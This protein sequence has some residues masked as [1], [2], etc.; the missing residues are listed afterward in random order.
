MGFTK[1]EI[2][3][4]VSDYQDALSLLGALVGFTTGVALVR[5]H[6]WIHRNDANLQPTV[7]DLIPTQ[8]VSA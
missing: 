5:R 8:S 4:L 7:L 1:R 6:A 2:G 3:S